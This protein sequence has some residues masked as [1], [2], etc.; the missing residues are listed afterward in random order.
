MRAQVLQTIQRPLVLSSLQCQGINSEALEKVARYSIDNLNYANLQLSYIDPD[1]NPSDCIAGWEGLPYFSAK[2]DYSTVF[3][4]A[5]VSKI[6]ISE[7]VLD[8]VRRQQ[9]SLDDKL[10][11]FLP[12]I[13]NKPLKDV[14]VADIS[15]S[16]LLSHRAGFDRTK[17]PDTMA[18]SSPWCPYH[19]DT[20]QQT[21]LDFEPNSKNIYANLGYCLLAQVIE[22]VYSKSYLEVSQDYFKFE[23]SHLYYIQE[24]QIDEPKIPNINKHKSLNEFDFYALLPVG[25]LAGNSNDLSRYVYNMDKQT[26]P[27]ITSRAQNINCDVT[28]VRGCHGFT[29]Y[30]YSI[31]DKLTFYWREGRVPKAITMVVMDSNGGVLSLLSNSENESYWLSNDQLLLETIYRYYLNE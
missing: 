30:E 12:E 23:R 6:F 22:N 20:L 26:Y 2:I 31:D 14:R 16:E 5:S 10:V 19:I 27:N 4:Y 8:L 28:Q 15:L 11:S 18:T 29:G 17:T 21:V 1:G 3:A 25:G 13:K 7:L 24:Q 9:I